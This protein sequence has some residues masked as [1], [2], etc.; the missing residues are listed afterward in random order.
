VRGISAT[1]DRKLSKHFEMGAGINTYYFNDQHDVKS[2]SALYVDARP[3]WAKRK[4]MF[5]MFVDIGAVY[6]AGP[7][8]DSVTRAPVTFASNLGCG[9]HY[10][11]NKR[12]MGPYV[13]LGL[14]GCTERFH[15]SK[16]IFANTKAQD[17]SLYEF[18]A[19]LSLGFKF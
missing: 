9:Y 16:A 6:N 13:S 7:M 17:Y 11:I 12:G 2:H 3:Y 10:R 19:I 4:S 14:Y 18:D 8:H 15:T 1:Y 5:F